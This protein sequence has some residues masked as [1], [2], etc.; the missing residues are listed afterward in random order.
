MR[1]AVLDDG[2]D[3][4]KQINRTMTAL[5]HECH[6]YTEGRALLQAMRRQTFDLLILGWNLP[7]MKGSEVVATI[8]R[9]LNSRLPILFVSDKPG[10]ADM[11]EGLNAGAG[12]FM[13]AF[14]DGLCP[15]GGCSATVTALRPPS[16]R[17]P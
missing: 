10:E 4:I 8:R 3:Q 1:I 7:D 17:S 16:S 14:G 6:P 9:D 15:A 13:A 5:E 11:V 12:D 2:V